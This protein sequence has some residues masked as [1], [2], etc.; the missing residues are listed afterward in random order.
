M[1]LP[2]YPTCQGSGSREQVN[3]S[4]LTPSGTAGESASRGS[5]PAR[6]HRDGSPRG[7]FPQDHFEEHLAFEDREFPLVGHVVVTMADVNDGVGD[8][9]QDSAR[10]S[11]G[12]KVAGPA[13]PP[14]GHIC[15]SLHSW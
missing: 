8:H 1:S 2:R 3:T 12:D 11:L 15:D 5:P 4:G 13:A 7:S 6:D 10:S 14:F 9:P